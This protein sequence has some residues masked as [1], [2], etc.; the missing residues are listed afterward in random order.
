[1]SD[2][3][4]LQHLSERIRAQDEDADAR[5]LA[6]IKAQWAEFGEI[7]DKDLLRRIGFS[8]PTF[9]DRC[10]AEHP[11]RRLW[12][13]VS[14]VNRAFN[15]LSDC[16]LALI[17]VAGSFHARIKHYVFD[18]ES[19]EHALREATKTIYTYSCAASSLVQAY[20]HLVSED[21][22]I[23]KEYD[24]VRAEIF[25]DSGLLEFFSQ[26]RKANNHLHILA[27]FPHYQV[28]R[29]FV[30]NTTVAKSGLSF[31]IPKLVRSKDWSAAAK[32]FVASRAD[33]DA[34]KLVEEHFELVRKFKRV[35]FVR[36]GIQAD[37]AYRDYARIMVAQDSVKKHVWLGIVLQQAASGDVNP[38]EYLDRWF[39]PA[40]LQRIYAF[41]DH[42]QEQLEF[43]IALR[44]P[45]GFCDRRT[46]EELYRLFSVPLELL[47]DQPEKQAR[48]DF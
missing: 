38:Y 48:I 25:V 1:M 14:N 41:R 30:A 31:S 47:P 27:A 16:R 7:R 34:V 19:E 10:L 8:S 45:L 29:D 12:E 22:E 2:T 21:E 18:E 35:V 44:D 42:T 26:L 40:E 33:L 3:H 46:R 17:D 36:T 9:V 13:N 28:T 23:R 43:M 15:I 5:R 4:S 11:A 6:A 39:T 32:A 20:R 37:V 24:A